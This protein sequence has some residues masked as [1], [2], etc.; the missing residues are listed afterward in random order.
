MALKS[1]KS[2]QK[3]LDSEIGAIRKQWK[4]R[5]SIALVYPNH[6]H[7]GMSSLGYQTLYDLLTDWIMWSAKELSCRMARGRKP[8]GQS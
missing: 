2:D 7:V 5:I 4:R 1:A 6:Y 8:S 3:F